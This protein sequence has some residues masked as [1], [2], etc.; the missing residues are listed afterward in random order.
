MRIISASFARK[1]RERIV[2]HDLFRS[3]DVGFAESHANFVFF[4]SGKPHQIVAA[5]LAARGINIGRSYP[6]LDSWVRISIGMPD[7]NAVAREAVAECLG[8]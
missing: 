5:A 3:L 8:R 6:L 2:W 1:S 7:D 4:D